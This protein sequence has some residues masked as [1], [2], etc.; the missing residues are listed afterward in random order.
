MLFFSIQGKHYDQSSPSPI[1]SSYETEWTLLIYL[2]A[3]PPD[4]QLKGG[5]TIFYLPGKQGKSIAIEPKA[6][7]ALLHRHGSGRE[8]LIHEGAPVRSGRK[9]VLRT[10]LL[11]G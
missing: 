7:M 10:D 4:V 6:G 1:T 2:S 11:F 8:C 5:E 3:P 9:W